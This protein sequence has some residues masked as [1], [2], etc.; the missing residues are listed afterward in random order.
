[1]PFSEF[2]LQI[3]TTNEEIGFVGQLL[4]LNFLIFRP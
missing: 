1:M 2:S 4:N 3:G